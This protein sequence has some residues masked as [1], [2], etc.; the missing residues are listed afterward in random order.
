MILFAFKAVVQLFAAVEAIP[1]CALA[2]EITIKLPNV[3]LFLVGRVRSFTLVARGCFV[4]EEKAGIAGT[5]TR[6]V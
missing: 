3:I 5:A 1:L 4:I 6:L 2:F